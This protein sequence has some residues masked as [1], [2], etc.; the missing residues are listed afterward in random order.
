MKKIL[1]VVF[2]ALTVCSAV[3]ST[4]CAADS[5]SQGD[6]DLN[7]KVEIS[8]VTSLQRHLAGIEAL[9]QNQKS[10]A[11][12]DLNGR[13]NIM[14]AT[15]IQKSLIGTDQLSSEQIAV[16]YSISN[17]VN[18]Y[19]KNTRNWDKVYFNLFN[20]KTNESENRPVTRYEIDSEGKQVY[21]SVVDVSKYD[22]VVFSNG[23]DKQ[24]FNVAMSKASSGFYINGGSGKTLT[25]GTYAHKNSG[26]GTLTTTTLN[27][28]DG[29][30]KKIWIW[31]PGDY[32]ADSA[33]KFKTIYMP[34]GQ[35]MFEDHVDGYGGWE[36][37]N[38][39]EAMMSNGG[40]GVIVVGIDNGNSKRNSELTPDL[41][42]IVSTNYGDYSVRT[43]EDYANFVV[44]KVMPYVQENYNSSPLREDNYVVG[45][46]SGGLESFYI[47]MEHKDKF[48]GIGALSPAFI[49]FGSNV[50]EDYFSKFDFNDEDMPRL[51]VFCGNS[52]KD[53]LEQ[54]LYSGMMPVYNMLIQK[55]YP[56][57]K[58]TLSLEE[59]F[60]HNESYWRVIFPETLTWLFEL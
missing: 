49:L 39:V 36:V 5:F 10:L 23:E 6:V 22:R 55:G 43:G 25:V 56:Q 57:D 28:S 20:S 52:P 32:S 30:D 47:G 4:A 24:T 7:G 51:Y 48:G 33:E 37:H 15:K 58:I 60:I 19:F 34:D 44:N 12:T 9:T 38:A 11:D 14:D 31:T 40:K 35:N 13:I 8:D 46:S 17:E 59:E 41:G 27:Y 16:D 1:S 45:S 26:A 18:I 3:S 42:E 21:S 50:W 29:Y 2:A 54:A 53:M